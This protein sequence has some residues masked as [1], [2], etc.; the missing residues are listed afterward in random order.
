[1]REYLWRWDDCA[2]R[3][4]A[5]NTTLAAVLEASE[6]MCVP[7]Q[8]ASDRNDD[9]FGIVFLI[10]FLVA[11]TVLFGLFVASFVFDWP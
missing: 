7:A 10:S 2:S 5:I 3:A 11:C 1:M 8:A 9:N 4:A 6:A